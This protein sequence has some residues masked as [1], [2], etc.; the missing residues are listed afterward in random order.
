MLSAAQ[1]ASLLEHVNQPL[2][3]RI[4]R[5]FQQTETQDP[6]K[7]ALYAAALEKPR[8]PDRGE[9]LFREKCGVCHQVHGVGVAVGPDL[10]AEFQRAEETIIRDILAPS[11]S[12]TAGYTAYTIVTTEGQIFSGLMAAEAANSVTLRQ[13]EGKTQAILRKNIDQIKAS[14]VSLMPDDLT[15]TLTPQ[16][17]A[18]ILAWLRSPPTKV[19]LID[20]DPA[21]VSALNLNEGGGTATFISTDQERGLFSL[22]VTPLQVSSASIKGWQYRI[23][24]KPEAGEFRYIRF[25]WKA[26]GASGVMIELADDQKWPLSGSP[27]RRYLA[28]KNGTPWQATSVASEAPSEWTVVV[29]DLWKDFGDMTLTGIAP[30][31]CGGPALF[32][33][34]E[35]LR[36]MPR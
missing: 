19:V 28:G 31:V 1:R 18:D 5:L 4:A 12:I 20:E 10:N 9:K 2:R 16:D 34:I 26:A 15:K 32:D 35:L 13:Q 25:A 24:E 22:H 7:F 29:R 27:E 3:E 14:P 8:D 11:S 36:T 30:T 23:R 6:Q 21:I 33:G 17:V